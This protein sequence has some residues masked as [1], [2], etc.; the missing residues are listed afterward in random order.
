MN[1]AS[2]PSMPSSASGRPDAAEQEQ[3]DR[4]AAEAPDEAFEQMRVRRAK[5]A[6][7]LAA[8]QPAVGRAGV[9]AD[10]QPGDHRGHV[11]R[12]GVEGGEVAQ[13]LAG[14]DARPG[15]GALRHQADRRGDLGGPRSQAE[16]AD[17]AAV[18]PDGRVAA[19]VS[20]S[21]RRAAP[22]VVMR[23]AGL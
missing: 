22:V 23:P 3:A 17:V 4:L 11:E 21:G 1:D 2:A 19:L 13:Q 5:R 20:E 14:P 10:A 15:A 7:L 12:M 18:G 8:G 16:H 9:R 6:E